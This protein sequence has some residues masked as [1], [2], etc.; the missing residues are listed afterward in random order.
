M[1]RKE[2]PRF[3]GNENNAIGGSNQTKTEAATSSVAAVS[4]DGPV[5]ETPLAG[6]HVQRTFSGQF[7]SMPTVLT[8]GVVVVDVI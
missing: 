2:T 7:K 6:V 1:K 3:L 8:R 4:M 5:A